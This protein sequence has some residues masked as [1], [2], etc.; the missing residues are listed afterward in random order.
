MSKERTYIFK[1]SDGSEFER[2]LNARTLKEVRE[3]EKLY[4]VK[5][6]SSKEKK[7]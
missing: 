4:G 1:F 6:V 5:L 3:Y 7:K 2:D